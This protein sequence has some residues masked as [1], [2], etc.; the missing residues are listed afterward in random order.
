MYL[1]T[2]KSNG[3]TTDLIH[4]DSPHSPSYD[5]SLFSSQRIIK[6][7]KRSFHRVRRFKE[8]RTTRSPQSDLIYSTGAYL[9]KFSIGTPPLPSI[10][11]ADTGNDIIWMQC[12]PCLQCIN[13]SLPIFQPQNYSTYTNIS[14][15]TPRCNSLPETYC[16]S[17]RNCLY[18]E[19]YEDG[20]FTYGQM[21]TDTFTL[22]S[23][24]RKTVSVP[25]ITFGCGFKNV[26][27]VM[28]LSKADSRK[29]GGGIS[30]SGR[31]LSD[32]EAI[33]KTFYGDKTLS[34]L[35]SSTASSRA[36]SVGKSA[37]VPETKLKPD[38]SKNVAKDS[39]DR[40]KKSSIWSWKGLKAL[41]HVRNR[42]FSCCF[43]LQVHS[44]DGLPA[45]FDGSCLVVHWKRRDA[46]QMTR[47]IRV[48]KGVAE[49][50]EQLTH[51]CSVYGSRSGPHH[52]AKYEA[53]HS[54]LFVSAYD[55]P[56]LDLGKH[57][58][59]LTR[60]LP[61]TLEELEEEKSSGKW[62]TSFRLSG[63]ARGAT[64]N[65]S[66][67]YVIENSNT[68]LSSGKSVSQIPSLQLNSAR[69]ANPLGPSDHMAEPDI[70]RA[71]SL[72]ARLPASNRSV[73]DI[74]D[75]HE[76]LPMPRSEL[77]ETMNILY[78]KMDEGASNTSID[79]KKAEVDS[80]SPLM[81]PHKV[82]LS[83]PPDAGEENCRT[84]CEISE[85]S[86][87]DK[88]I[89]ELSKEHVI[90]EGEIL[91]IAQ[92]TGDGLETDIT[93]K[94]ALDSTN[95]IHPSPLEVSPQANEQLIQTWNY[96]EQ[97]KGIS[98]EEPPE[99]EM[100]SPLSC[101]TDLVNE[102]L[103]SQN[104]E[105]D[106]SH[107]ESYLEADSY[108]SDCRKGKSLSLDDVTDS[109]ASDFLEMLGIEHSP[110]NMSSE[111]EPES[112]RECLLRQFEKEALANG[113]L[114]NFDIENDPVELSSD[115][116]MGS[117][118]GT[119]SEDFHHPP[120]FEGFEEMSKIDTDAFRAETRASRME[121]L[122]NEALM[123]E[124]GLNEKAFQH[125]PP[126]GSGFGSP[127]DM[128]PNDPLQLPPLT[129][130]LG[131]FVQ[132]RD[133]GFL[134]SMSPALFRNAKSGGS[135]IM[136]V[137]NSVVVPAVMGSGV[138]DILQGLASIGIEKLSMQANKLMP[139]E[140]LTGK[141]IQQ[142]AWE[143][144]LCLEEP[145]R[146]DL[147]HQESE[148]MN[149]MYHGK[150][151]AKGTTTVQRSSQLDS[152]SLSRDTEYVSLED[153]APL[154]MD[155]IEALSVEGLRIQSGMSDEDAPSNISA[156][157]IGEFSAL[158]GKTVDV[159]GSIGLDGTCGLQLLDIKDNGEDVDG[160]MGL[161]LTLDEWMKLDSGE[162][163][164]DDLAS[165][166]TSKI[167]AAHHATSLDQFRG[168]SKGEKRRGK[169]KKYGLLGNNFTVALMVQ[170][171]DPLRN[172]EP[173]GT[174][175][176]ALIQVE[177]VGAK[178]EIIV[179]KPTEEKINEEELIPQY[180]ITEVHVAGLKAEQGKKKLWGSTNQQQ[181]GSRWLLA[182]GMGKKN[183]H[184]LMKSKAVPKPSASATT[185]TTVQP[186]ETLWS[187]SSRVHGTGDKWKE[188]AALNPHIRNPN[189]IFPNETIRL[190]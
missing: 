12:Q 185:T 190:R 139:L 102:K 180:K 41:T 42:R 36:K 76:I 166:R 175:M 3:F 145:E 172:Y 171:R 66:F 135:L 39:F 43:S 61:I 71:G 49:F 73:E 116:P 97:E 63:K 158:K 7:L 83:G 107:L 46:E 148:V 75:L 38:D 179:E 165:E 187:I 177:R 67:G 54:L 110:F 170:L 151:S 113:G 98:F 18:S 1:C 19:K 15:N 44:I 48:C 155:K 93:A 122:E 154:A 176:L 169:N 21:A 5:P 90:P 51:S 100:E 64:I 140:D 144:E 26:W 141:T 37:H 115:I 88:G 109:V 40:D 87:V 95:S 129:E 91:K 119:V 167:L 117:S 152:S 163:D 30:G 70:H 56:E 150:K 33:N 156:Q 6:A 149:S 108:Y 59:D 174:P 189:V 137:S 28:M 133:G 14:C 188:L 50:E 159:G 123:R 2:T 181:S 127:I 17:R 178:K 53:K 161:S 157:S 182:N 184:P 82:D 96:A 45:L 111:S 142:I 103:E 186:G 47:P 29:K 153:L 183:K 143:G 11:I 77:L 131:S 112:P 105:T 106:A 13:Q 9:M 128:P 126:S 52:S 104:D 86:V 160:L 23:T 22:A 134:R 80:L 74:K 27:E 4:I 136:Q 31:L 32:L 60:L 81:D 8:R 35:A 25:K 125:S 72:P 78:Q 65:V 89:E 164:D 16:S 58:I 146:Q 34:R 69:T 85:F 124:W 132:T 99:Q 120:K 68:E 55:A 94:V 20:S 79:N 114:L 168:R 24:G 147:L 138:M 162:I 173:V 84:E 57:R 130:G 101:I 10:A 62:T 118:W 92:G 121:D